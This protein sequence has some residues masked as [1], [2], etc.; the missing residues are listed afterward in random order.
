MV[1]D[2]NRNEEVI[3]AEA[4]GEAII[5]PRVTTFATSVEVKDTGLGIVQTEHRLN[6]QQRLLLQRQPK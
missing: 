4:V 2:S 5:T 1:T 6:S 3:A